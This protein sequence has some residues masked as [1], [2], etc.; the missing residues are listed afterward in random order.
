MP[1][2]FRRCLQALTEAMEIN[3]SVTSIKLKDNEIGAE[4]AKAMV[5][6]YLR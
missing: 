2:R 5:C 6:G 4:I 1:T 3:K